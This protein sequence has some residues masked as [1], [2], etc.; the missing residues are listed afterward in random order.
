[1]QADRFGQVEKTCGQAGHD[2]N[3]RYRRHR[4]I[5]NAMFTEAGPDSEGRIGKDFA[6]VKACISGEIL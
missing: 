5:L 6:D 3:G 4:R 1:M 2:C